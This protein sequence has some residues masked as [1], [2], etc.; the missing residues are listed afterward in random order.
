MV[1]S[2]LCCGASSCRLICLRSSLS[3]TSWVYHRF[4]AK[5]RYCWLILENCMWK[6]KAVPFYLGKKEIIP[7]LTTKQID[8]IMSMTQPSLHFTPPP[9]LSDSQEGHGWLPPSFDCHTDIKCLALSGHN[10]RSHPKS[11]WSHETS[12]WRNHGEPW[13]LD[14]IACNSLPHR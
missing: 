6:G 11:H 2:S 10:S 14:W 12:G 4:S 7:V 5:L 3:E 1:V 9:P 13:M 8:I